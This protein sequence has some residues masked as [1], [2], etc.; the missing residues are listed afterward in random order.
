MKDPP[1]AGPYH[2]SSFSPFPQAVQP[3]HHHQDLLG[4]KVGATAGDASSPGPAATVPQSLETPDLEGFR[5]GGR[6]VLLQKGEWSG[7]VLVRPQPSA[8]S[9]P[10]QGQS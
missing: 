10:Q 6:T 8:T 3:R 9:R 5:G 1:G 2:T 7:S 4:R